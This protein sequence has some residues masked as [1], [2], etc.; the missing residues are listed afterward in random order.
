MVGILE[1]N[2][3]KESEM[4]EN[5]WRE[6]MRTKLIMKS[7]LNGKNKMAIN[8]RAVSLMRYGAGIVKWTRSNHGNK[9]MGCFFDEI[10]CRY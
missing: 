4:K 10:W 6:Y 2:K 1:Y 3:I 7:R 8:T 5:L 9:Y